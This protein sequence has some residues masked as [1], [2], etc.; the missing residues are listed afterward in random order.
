MYDKYLLYASIGAPPGRCARCGET[1]DAVI[2]T[3][4]AEGKE[5]QGNGEEVGKS[6]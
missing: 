4:A 2:G 1:D 6:A 3:R 5:W